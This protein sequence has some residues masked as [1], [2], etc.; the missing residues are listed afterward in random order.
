M[1]RISRRHITEAEMGLKPGGVTDLFDNTFKATLRINDDE[2]D[3]I[4]E[5]GSDEE[6]NI[7]L[8]EN[9]TFE[10]GRKVILVRNKLV[11]QYHAEQQSHI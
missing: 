9:I 8:T 4:C 11:A 7:L 10:A 6:L 1:T 5:Q 3:Y 2:Y